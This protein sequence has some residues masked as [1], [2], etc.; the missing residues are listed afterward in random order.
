[1]FTPL[2]FGG[3]PPSS[4]VHTPLLKTHWSVMRYSSNMHITS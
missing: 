1:M 2:C 3:T 4:G